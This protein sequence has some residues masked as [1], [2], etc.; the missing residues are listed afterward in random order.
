MTNLNE[1]HK[2]YS[3]EK[4][5]SVA[6]ELQKSDPDWKFIVVHSPT[7]TGYSFIEVYDEDG[8]FV[9]RW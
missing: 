5:E 3:R 7:P 9:K 1:P 4:A 8:E 6:A 2:L